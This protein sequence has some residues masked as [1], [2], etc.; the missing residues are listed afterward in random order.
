MR[1]TLKKEKIT[2]NTPFRLPLLPPP[3][4]NKLW[5]EEQS[6]QCFFQ[7]KLSLVAGY[8]SSWQEQ[9]HQYFGLFSISLTNCS[10]SLQSLYFTYHT[11]HS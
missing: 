6:M 2:T 10:F 4:C 8:I 9:W 7:S 5:L 3:R 1:F 11:M